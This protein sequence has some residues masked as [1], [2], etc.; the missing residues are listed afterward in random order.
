MNGSMKKKGVVTVPQ[1]R[2]K[3]AFRAMEKYVTAYSFC[4][5]SI[6]TRKNSISNIFVFR[7]LETQYPGEGE[8]WTI[9]RVMSGEEFLQAVEERA[10]AGHCGNPICRNSVN[11]MS[12]PQIKHLKLK[13]PRQEE[14]KTYCCAG[15]AETVDGFSS[16]LGTSSQAL[17]R[18]ERLYEK[19]K[20][21]RE[22]KMNIKDE[23]NAI[24]QEQKRK[25]AQKSEK[26]YA[27]GTAKFPIMKTEV[28]E[29][30]VD[31]QKINDDLEVSMDAEAANARSLDIEGYTPGRRGGL[32]KSQKDAALR[33][34][35]SERRVRFSNPI[36]DV[37]L[38]RSED[39]LTEQTQRDP[40]LAEK[41]VFI[42]DV[43]DAKG[44]IEGLNHPLEATFGRLRLAK[45][46]EI[47]LAG[48]PGSVRSEQ[49][50]VIP[51][52]DIDQSMDQDLG[53]NIQQELSKFFPHLATKEGVSA[54]TF[55][56]DDRASE[57]E[58]DSGL[59]SSDAWSSSEDD[60]VSLEEGKGSRAPGLSF[61]LQLYTHLDGWVTDA[62]I[63]YMQ[64]PS[65]SP[66]NISPFAG[67]V[68][69]I[70][71]AFR[72]LIAV[73]LPIV[74][75][76]MD[77]V[78]FKIQIERALQDLM[79]TFCFQS[80]LPAFKSLQ[81]QLVVLLLLKALSLERLAIIRPVFETRQGIHRVCTLLA[82][83]KFTAEEFSSA[84]ELL[85]GE[86]M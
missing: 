86:D 71:V 28:Q 68:P 76:R 38:P 2:N 81:W 45:Q 30:P 14:V 66:A 48:L 72:R 27:A 65:D 5:L 13:A 25:L 34:D 83:N 1:L 82:E 24:E 55:E 69:E 84:L 52:D 61:F 8:L 17:Q 7:M 75:E 6:N 63:E 15:C 80:A 60:D 31:V 67:S 11:A 29:K 58:S 22:A 54:E 43:E 41:A 32:A 79:L 42:L 47:G 26:L 4:T 77:A 18:F 9:A 16:R 23:C 57:S 40:E 39:H 51:P 50:A 35:R 46:E 62:T 49:P 3:A 53:R 56:I 36:A 59:E 37:G 78:N 70:S 12:S 20:S 10:L 85:V 73:A 33:S 44:P 64:S 74:L 21:M 19:V